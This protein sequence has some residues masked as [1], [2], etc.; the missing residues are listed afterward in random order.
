MS[1]GIN[2]PAAPA[3][4]VKLLE[5]MASEYRSR[6]RRRS[7]L[8]S[9]RLHRST[10]QAVVTIPRSGIRH[11]VYLGKYG[12]RDS[13]KEYLRT[14]SSFLGMCI[15]FDRRSLSW[16]LQPGATF[17]HKRV[18][19]LR[20]LQQLHDAIN[21]RRSELC[22]ILMTLAL[23]AGMPAPPQPIALVGKK[24]IAPATSG[25]YFLWARGIQSSPAYVG[26][27]TC[28]A[29]RVTAAHPAFCEGDSASWLLR[30]PE[31]IRWD[32]C[33]YIWLLR[34]SRNGQS[35]PRGV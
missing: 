32:E 33:F 34:P 1:D 19:K 30:P 10:G 18:A 20:E 8:P 9:Y 35:L 7:G 5:A 13:W 24:P 17:R 21:F 6:K 16:E 2:P 12:S 25:V 4:W 22:Q 28:L 31:T 14:I 23:P 11:A 27:S 15:D 3:E 26:Q 29:K